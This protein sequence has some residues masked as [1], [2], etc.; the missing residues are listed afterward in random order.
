M[1]ATNESEAFARAY[2]QLNKAQ[3]KAVDTVDGPVMVIAGPGTGKTQILTL[4]IA[5]ILLQTDTAP[6]NIL[7]LTFTESGAKAMRERLVRYI[8]SAAYR[9][10]ITTFH[11]FAGGLI[12]Q[13]PD[14]YPT[15]VG[16]QAATDLD[17]IKIIE[18]ILE[19]GQVDS[20][21]PGGNPQ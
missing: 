3:K 9:V 12:A 15:V 4:R 8:G 13:Y 19:S 20:L 21:R 2:K 14:A 1:S 16:G 11:S 7:A 6:D 5:N 10:T 18:D 17:R